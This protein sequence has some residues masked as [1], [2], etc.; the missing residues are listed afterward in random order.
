MDLTKSIQN[1][2]AYAS[3]VLGVIGIHHA[4]LF[5]F[6]EWTSLFEFVPAVFVLISSIVGMTAAKQAM[7][8]E[9]E[10]FARVGLI[11]NTLSLIFSVLIMLIGS[12][13]FFIFT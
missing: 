11:L 9:R 10:I 2:K 12:I 1:G 4:L 8:S 6:H 7:G 3:F 5:S 13:C